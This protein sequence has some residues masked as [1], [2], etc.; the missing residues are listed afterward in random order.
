MG[1][2]SKKTREEFRILIFRALESS[3]GRFVDFNRKVP[4]SSST[5]TNSAGLFK[6]VASHLLLLLLVIAIGGVSI[7]QAYSQAEDRDTQLGVKT[8]LHI[9]PESVRQGSW[10]DV[11]NVLSPDLDEEALYQEFSQHNSAHVPLHSDNVEENSTVQPEVIVPEESPSGQTQQTSDTSA[12]TSESFEDLTTPESVQADVVTEEVDESAPQEIPSEPEPEPE[13]EPEPATETSAP[14]SA[15]PVALKKATESFFAFLGTVTEFFPF[16]NDAEVTQDAAVVQTQEPEAAPEEEA[17]QTDESESTVE[18]EPQEEVEETQMEQQP[19]TDAVLSPEEGEPLESVPGNEPTSEE[20]ATSSTELPPSSESAEDAGVQENNVPAESDTPLAQY[21]FTLSDFS[22]PELKRGEFIKSMQLRMSLAGSYDVQGSSSAPVLEIYYKTPSSTQQVGTVIVDSEVSNALNGGYFLFALPQIANISELNEVE[23]EVIYK[24]D[25]AQLDGMYV[26]TAWLQIEVEHLDKDLLQARLMRDLLKRLSDP[27]MYTLLSDEVDFTREELPH[28]NLKYS[29]QRNIAVRFIRDLFGRKLAEIEDVSFLHKDIG[30]IGITPEIDITDD[31]LINIQLEE[32]DK[33]RL[34]PGEYLVEITINEGGATYTDTFAFQWGLLSINSDQTSYALGDTA[35]ISMGALSP[36]GNT[37]CDADLSL[38]V[39]DPQEVLF[40]VPVAQSGL[41]NG[42]NVIDVPDY[43]ATFIPEI[44]GEYEMYLERI[45][46]DG[47]IIAHTVD[48]FLV[49]EVLPFELSRKGPSRI[50]PKASYPMEISLFTNDAWEGTLI[51]QVP[52]DF[53]IMDTDAQIIERS[54]VRELVWDVALGAGETKTF[55]YTFDAPD[56]SPYLYTLGTARLEGIV[57]PSIEQATSTVSESQASSTTQATSTEES[58]PEPIET[59][60]E[61]VPEILVPPEII[62]EAP[63]A[64]T[65]ESVETETSSNDAEASPEMV[66]TSMEEASVVPETELQQPSPMESVVATIESGVLF[67]EHRQWQIASDA[68]GNL[69]VFW[70]SAA[71]I[72]AGWTCLSCGSGT[73]YQRFPM[74]GDTYNTTGGAT[75]HTHTATGVVNAS[76]GVNTENNGSGEISI[77]SHSHLYTPTISTVS[78]LPAYRQYRVIQNNSAGDPATIP[79]GA[80]MMFD[81]ATLPSGWTRLSALDGR[82]LRG[83]NSIA[84]GSS[85]T[86]THSISGN[87]TAASNVSTL[88]SRTGGFQVTGAADNH[89]HSVSTTTAS[90]SIEP[91]YIEVVFATAASATSTPIGAIAMWSDEPPAQW[92]D[93]SSQPTDPFNGRFV[94]GATSYGTTGGS[95]THNHADIFSIISGNPTVTDNARSGASGSSNTHTHAVDVTN[96]TTTSHLPPYLTVVYGKKLGAV[97]VYTQT[98]YRFY[99][100]ENANTP[101]DPWPVGGAD[102]LENEPITSEDIPLA[103][104]DVVRMRMLLGVTNST[105]TA[106]VFKLQY[107]STT[108]LCTDASTWSD[109]GSATSSSAW[110]GYENAGVSDGATLATSTLSSTTV[111]ASYEEN[112]PTV[113]VPNPIGVGDYGEWDFV[114]QQNNAEAGT[115]YCFR[116]V[117]QDGTPLF[118]YSDYPTVQTNEAPNAPTLVKLFDNEK[119]STTTPEFEFSAADTETDDLEYQIQIDNDYDFSSAVVDHNTVTNATLFENLATPADKDPFTNGELIRYNSA[120]A[121]SNGTTYYWRVRARDPNGSNAWGSWATIQSFTIDTSVTVSTWFQTTEEQFETNT[122]L[123]VEAV[124]SDQMQILS[125]FATGT[126]YSDPITFEEGELGTAWGEF[127]FADTET[128]SDVKYTIQYNDNDTWTDIPDTDLPGNSSGFDTSPVSLLGVDKTVY[129][130]L[131]IEANLTDSGASPSIQ[132]WSVDWDYLIETPTISAPFANEKVGTT[133]PTFQFTTTDPQSDDLIYQIQWSTSYDFSA[134]TTRT[135]NTHAGFTNVDNGADTSPFTSGDDIRFKIQAGDAL[136]NGTTYWWRVRARDPLGS[137]TY[138]FYT[139]PRSFTV[140]TT[141]TVSTWFQTTQSQ[142]DNDLLSGLYTQAGG[143]LTVATTSDE[144]ILVYAEGTVTT[145][146]YRRWSG[147]AW[148]SELSA[149]DVGATI[150]WV[151]TKSSPIANEYITGTLGSDGDVNL[152][153]F[154]NGAWGNLEE[155]STAISNNDMRGFDIAYESDS[156]DALAVACDG[157]ADPSY[158]IWDGSSWSDEGDIDLASTGACG[159]VRL[160]SD[161]TSDE[162][163]VI[164]RDTVGTNYEAQ[165]WDG[166]S[167]GDGVTWGSMSEDINEGIAASYE[168]SGGQA[169]VAVSNGGGASFSWRAWNGSTWTAAATVALGDDFEWGSMASDVGSDNMA[170]CYVDNDTDIGVVRWTGA[171]WTGQTELDTAGNSKNSRPVDCMFEVGGSRD[172]YIMVAYSDTTAV[173]YRSWNGGSWAAEATISTISDASTIQ[174][175]RTGVHLLQLMAFDDVNDRYDYSDWNGTS[176]ST[177]Q[178]LETNGSVGAAP[179]KEPFMIGVQNPASFGTVT[180]DPLINFSEGSGPYWQQMSWTDTTTGGSDILYQVEYYD[181]DSWELIPDSL[182]PGNSTGTSTGPIDLTNVLPASTYDQIRPVATLSCNAGTCPILSDWTITWAAGLN[183]SGTAQ[184]YDQSTNLTSGT[185]AIAVNG[186]LQS[187]KTG[188]IAAGVWSITNVNVAQDDVV[189]VFLAGAGDSSEAVAVTTYDGVGDVSGLSLF[190]QHL[191]LGSDDNASL[192]NASLALYDFTNDEDIFSDVNA[193]NDLSVCATSGCDDAVLYIKAGTTYQPGTGANVT[194]HGFENNG[195]FLP[196]GNTIRVS[197][198]WENNATTTMATSSVIFTATT[199]QSSVPWYDSQWSHRLPLTV[200]SSQIDTSVTDFPV[201]VDLSDLDSI[202][203]SNVNSDGGDI[204]VT[205]AD[206]QTE[207][208]REIVSIDTGAETGEIHFQADSLSSSGDTTFYIYFGN[209]SASDYATNGT[210]GAEN[211]WN[212]SYEA[213]YHFEEDPSGSAPQYDDST[214]NSAGTAVN[215]EGADQVAGIAGNAAEVDGANE[216]IQ[217]NFNQALLRSTWS[218][219]LNADGTQGACDGAMFSRGANVSGINLGACGATGEIG[220]HWNDSATTYN[221]A[222]G[223]AYP[224]DEWFLASLVVEPTQ[225]T[226][227][228]H[229]IG[230]V[231]SGSNVV[232]HATSTINNLDFAWDSFGVA[233]S[234]DGTIDEARLSSVARAEDWLDAEYRNISSPGTFYSVSAS[235]SYASSTSGL[236]YVLSDADGFLDFYNLTFGEVSGT[237]VW[238][239]QDALDVENTLT[240]AYGTLARGSE[241]ITVAGNLTTQ[242]NGLWTG[243]GTTTFD[244]TSVGIWSDSSSPKQDIGYVV[245]NGVTK[246][247]QLGSNV[248]AASITIGADD[249]FDLSTSNYDIVVNGNWINNHTFNPRNGD[250]TFSGTTAGQVITVGGDNFYN[251]IFNGAGGSWS[252]TEGTL[253]INNDLTIVTGTITLPTGTTTISGSF[254]NSGGTFAHNNAMVYFNSS[255]AETLT[256]NGGTFTNAFYNVRFQ[257]SGSWAFTEAN[258]TTTNQFR[259]AQGNVTLPSGTLTVGDSFLNTGGTFTHNSGTVRF[260]S[261]GAET[262]DTNS[263]FNNLSFVGSGSWSFIDASVT[264]LGDLIIDSGTL[265]LPSGTLSLGGSLSNNATLSHNNGTVLFNSGDTGETISLG[266]SPLY[267]MTFNGAGGGWTINSH[268]T[269]TNNTTITAAN[270]FTL[271]SSQR[272]S[273]GGTFTNSVGGAA[274]TWTGSTLSLEA[275]SY[276][277]NAKANSGDIYETLLI[278]PNTDIRMWNSSAGTYTVDASSSLYSQDHAGVD[279][280]LYIYGNYPRTSGTEYWSYATDFDGTSLGTTSRQVDVRFAS[281]ASADFIDSTVHIVGGASAT[282]TIANQGSGTYTLSINGGTTTAQYYSFTD[283]AASGVTLQGDVAV[284]SLANGSFVPAVNTGTALTISST[285][286]DANP[287]LQ[288][289]NVQFAT[290]TAI[291]ASNVTQQDGVP[292]SYWWFRSS[293]G[294]L[295]GETHDNDNGDPGSIRWDDSSLVFTVAGTVYADNGVTPLAGGTC[296]GVATPVRVVVENGGTFNGS[297]SALDGSYSIPNVVAIGDPTLTVFLNDASGGERAVVV[298]K[299]PTQDILDLDLYANRIITRHEDTA[300]MTISDMVYDSTDDSDVLFTAVTGAV[301]TL[302]TV[303]NSELYVWATTTFTPGGAVTLHSGG[304]GNAYDGSLYISNGATFTGAGTT[305]YSVGGT[306]ALADGATFVS[307]S[308]TVLM[309]ATTSGKAITAAS[310]ESITFN[311]LRF[312]GL[313]GGWNINGDIT[314][315]D[316]IEV[317]TGTVTG[318]GDISIP[319]GSFYGEGLVS[320]G[321]GTTT[322]ER[323]NTLGGSQGWTLFNVALGNGSDV[324]TTTPASTATT[325][326]SGTLSIA[327]AHF[328]DAGASHFDFAGTGTVFVENGTFLED[329]STVRYSGGG[330]TNLLSTTYYDLELNAGAGT[331]TYTATGLGIMV[332]NDL[333]VGGDSTTS[334]TFDTN[335]TALD[336]NGTVLIRSNGTLI[337]SGSGSFTVGGDWDNNGVYTSSNG[338]VVFDGAGTVDI[339]AGNSAFGNLTVDGIGTFTVSEHATTTGAFTLASTTSSFTLASGQNLAIGGSFTNELGGGATTWTGSTLRFV[340]GT[341]YAINAKTISD[342]YETLAVGANTDIRMWNSSASSYQVNSSGSLYSQ[343]HAGVD[344]DL[345]IYG[346]YSGNGGTDYWSYATDFDGVALGGSSRQAEVRFQS[347]ANMTLLSG[348]LQVLGSPSASTTL[349][350]QGSGTYGLLI[351][352]SASTSWTYYDVEDTNSSGLTFSGSP[353]VV[354]LSRGDFEVSQSGGSAITVG[355]TAINANPAKTFTNNNFSTTTGISAFN[356]TATGTSV[357]SWRFTNHTGTLDG[358]QYDV[359]PDGDPGYIVWDNSAAN[360]TISGNVYSDE[361]TTVSGVCDGTTNNIIV[362]VAGLTSYT[363]SCNA[364][365]G[366]YSVSGVTYSPGD[367]IVAYIDG[368]TQKGA[369]VTEDPV[370]NINNMHIYENRVIARHEGTDSLSIADMAVWDSSDD[371]DIPFTAVDGSPDT[372]TLPSDRKLIVWTGKNLSQ[373]E[374]SR[375][376]AEEQAQR[377]TA[378]LRHRQMQL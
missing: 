111:L 277:L 91:P 87:T 126:V 107:A 269:T 69:I 282:T 352:G 360:I 206:G 351:G 139:T 213:V 100:N 343:D 377:M 251:L 205:N 248:E 155:I 378:P 324:G 2:F 129:T 36:S 95:D 199:T 102:L 369:T 196:N 278:K 239:L 252:F 312:T 75:T 31:G 328:L 301:P 37:I 320:L 148:G 224:T 72:P 38:Y 105:S 173:R 281:G 183:V 314:A 159:W 287:G 90:L 298:T 53:E 358:E 201:Y 57:P 32:D 174:L 163:I 119:V 274:T 187:G 188:T 86:H 93:R 283:L 192:S 348:G 35:V 28:F 245:V 240:V 340:S 238:Q 151:V 153:V 43:S 33:D 61:V 305:T 221:W 84:N 309:T 203:F 246:V 136:T 310:G 235:E 70:D 141:V 232:A 133:T 146:R 270:A 80:I 223:P 27:S 131:R 101:S 142:F 361:G 98:S 130:E 220:Y 234:F 294:N 47:T 124:A 344:G 22:A 24:G 242:A 315:L 289:F 34:R 88:N 12:T 170:L 8:T 359:D 284:T 198:S 376:Q 334:V 94:K 276:S 327:T 230:G 371:A 347:G 225:A 134:S 18:P 263:S 157:N 258:A 76:T 207:L 154:S 160:I 177:R 338:T 5:Q 325:T 253:S 40:K 268:A 209:S 300:A 193:G 21:A 317:A 218:L 262:I 290:S 20:I 243:I 337:G 233:R 296:D 208:P 156:G 132:S 30:D 339:A 323:S 236:P 211:V 10:E 254:N 66:E 256:L 179:F 58:V 195:T 122:L 217:T 165:V 65:S 112:N 273:V 307:A 304:T 127:V 169:V 178:A 73:F 189:T 293:S 353:N 326:I 9:Y 17:S 345:Y 350:N 41:C 354:T 152:Q 137:N 237:S 68:T 367:S 181:G 255:A 176:W 3:T 333:A 59:E 108:A 288:I 356:V 118:A 280:D 145:P 275:G 372:L 14:E 297:C 60:P 46:A 16:M 264:A 321:G 346:N 190:T 135:S 182:I 318:T 250:V 143:A 42:N 349:Q 99:V 26:D 11:G 149:L 29:S 82:Y 368:E 311:L 374:I 197:G 373:T 341:N 316:E 62:P 292:S 364:T 184:Q 267:N 55:T 44:E 212:N 229:A 180:G 115:T 172:G 50:Y 222:N 299:T 216:S 79:A 204:R 194:T 4:L 96:F 295:G 150:N 158:H 52:S 365:T 85:N 286:I 319:N 303:A 342:T 103:S 306:F 81:D 186:V 357:S 375:S 191:S 241:N 261:S 138:S 291:T 6:K 64:S 285:T 322:L 25:T 363:S 227:Y 329:T 15:Q 171:A 214:G 48:T 271:A 39:I 7:K 247:V 330:A 92:I 279:G 128:S 366:L 116:M 175:Q 77:P 355:G 244:G 109:V 67:E 161:P 104:G 362:R 121:L 202:F 19:A 56:I 226:V 113:A 144:S 51:E 249:T 231:T 331:P 272:L 49:E 260:T 71:A 123:N 114:V 45:D 83:E 166:S 23:V 259:I 266:T 164:T 106:D 335:D 117:E 200:Q 257:G 302:D 370:S 308:S 125:P 54:G 215:M 332:L 210:Y 89:A 185:V 140:D 110:R 147:T 120:T 74:G 167:W 336:V 13:S 313:G 168:E 162:I 219:F 1:L 97:P 265:T 78:N 63:V 228:A